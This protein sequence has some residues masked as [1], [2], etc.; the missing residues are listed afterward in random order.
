MFES[1]TL[2]LT[3]WYLLGVMLL[4][5]GFSVLVYNSALGEL[6]ARLDI[7][8]TRLQEREVNLSP[9]FN[10]S[11][12]REHQLQEATANILTV[13]I[14][15]NLIILA[16]ASVAS[17]LWARQT[18]RPIEE[19]HEA[20]GR[21]TSDASHELRTPL[22]VMQAEIEM[23]LR[24]QSATKA[25]YRDT[26]VSNQE[27]VIRLTRLSTLLLR[28][29]QLD[30]QSLSWKEKN[31]HTIAEEATKTFPTEQRRRIHI[32]SSKKAV[33]ATIN[34]ESITELLVI[35]LDNALKYSTPHT[36]ISVKLFREKGKRCF[37]ITNHGAGIE[38]TEINQI[39]HRFYRADS[40]RT[41]TSVGG[42]GL[43]LSLAQKIVEL[44]HGEIAVQSIPHKTTSFTVKLP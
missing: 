20:Q 27:E 16:I 14:Y 30:T 35:L 38:E 7:I 11:T 17:Y 36:E 32:Q 1:A 31:L 10:F 41:K 19:A 8:G 42:Y 37:S 4:S 43:G 29:A 21:F 28:L 24:D 5:L 39:F 2:K 25:D 22:S 3:I 12:V 34:K 6:E 15:S 33:K 40:S 26:L 18:L 23:V 13:L 9:Q 44:H